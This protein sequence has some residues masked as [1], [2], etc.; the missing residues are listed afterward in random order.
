M[1]ILR[2]QEL[3]VRSEKAKTHPIPTPNEGATPLLV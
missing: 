3:E 2:R 1:F